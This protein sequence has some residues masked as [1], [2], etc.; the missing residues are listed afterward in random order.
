MTAST[1]L[2][3]ARAGGCRS[4]MLIINSQFLRLVPGVLR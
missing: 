4:G 1:P 2:T 3:A